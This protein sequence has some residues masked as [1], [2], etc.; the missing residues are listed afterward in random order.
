M[1]LSQLEHGHPGVV[2]VFSRAPVGTHTLFGS[3]PPLHPYEGLIRYSVRIRLF[4]HT[5]YMS[6][7][8]NTSSLD[9][10]GK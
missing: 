3:H 4:I 9:D 1:F 10:G 7:Q 6:R 5:S 2:E 8:W